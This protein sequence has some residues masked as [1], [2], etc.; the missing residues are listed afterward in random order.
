MTKMEKSILNEANTVVFNYEK[1]R[2]RFLR[3]VLWVIS[4]LGA[5][6]VLANLPSSFRRRIHNIYIASCCLIRR[7]TASLA[8]H[9]QGRNTDHCWISY[10]FIQFDRF[11]SISRRHFVLSCNHH[12]LFVLVRPEHRMVL[13]WTKCV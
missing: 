9:V 10:W 5:F 1:W 11:W 4:I 3:T 13:V 12:F 6:L 7:H 8:L 2:D